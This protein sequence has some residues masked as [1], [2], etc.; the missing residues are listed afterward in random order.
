MKCIVKEN[1]ILKDYIKYLKQLNF[2][3]FGNS[4]LTNTSKKYD[5]Q[6]YHESVIL[7]EKKVSSQKSYIESTNLLKSSENIDVLDDTIYKKNQKIK[8]ILKILFQNN[9]NKLDAVFR[10]VVLIEKLKINITKKYFKNKNL[11]N[12][13]LNDILVKLKKIL[14]KK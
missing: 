8:E 5:F 6:K 13:Y 14:L 11:N 4:F 9:L 2:K 12:K 1:L 7:F 3:N 10:K